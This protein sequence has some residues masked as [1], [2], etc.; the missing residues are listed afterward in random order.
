MQ[1]DDFN[2]L[3]FVH[4]VAP[5]PNSECFEYDVGCPN[6][7]GAMVYF[8]V[9]VGGCVCLGDVDGDQFISLADLA[10]L[11][12]RFGAAVQPGDECL[13]FD[14]DGVISIADLSE[15]LSRFGGPCG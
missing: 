7:L 4:T 8:Q 1:Y 12:G 13:D 3:D 11:L 10:A 6:P 2:P 9:E 15:A 5:D 14:S